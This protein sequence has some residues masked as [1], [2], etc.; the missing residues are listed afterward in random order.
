MRSV[1]IYTAEP[2]KTGTEVTLRDSAARH[3]GQVLRK[4][5]GDPLVLFDGRG[6]EFAATIQEINKNRVRVEV[7]QATTPATESS[8][9][10][11]LWHGLCRSGRMDNVIQKA[12]EL[13]VS[14]IQPVLTER[15]IVKL[16]A[17]KAAKRVEHWQAVAISACEQSGRSIVPQILVP[18]KLSDALKQLDKTQCALLLHPDGKTSLATAISADTATIVLTGPEGGF[19][20]SEVAAATA[21]G[22]T[23]V[24]LGKRIMQTE[25]A[26]VVALGL[27]QYLAGDLAKST[28]ESLP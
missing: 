19:T 12:T 18:L 5:V 14:A 25:T 22:F 3:I 11:S 23:A 20:D 24:S 1:R 10:L 7:A 15:G 27:V 28:P 4:R 13:G 21:A 6:E 26:P 8:L 9:Q 17:A 16:D 2:L